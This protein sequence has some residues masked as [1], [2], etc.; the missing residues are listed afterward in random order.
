MFTNVRLQHFRSYDDQTVELNNGVNIV[1]G[2]NASGKTNLLEGLFFLCQGTGFRGKDANLIKNDGDWLRADGTT[3][4]GDRTFI[5]KRKEEKTAPEKELRFDGVV[6]KRITQTHT[7]PVTLFEPEHLRLLVG[8]PELRRGYL[9]AIIAQ[10]EHGLRQTL[11]EYRR[12]LSH[13]NRLL[14]TR[15][16]DM[17][18]QIFVWN[19]RLSELGADI[20]AQR[21]L[22]IDEINAQASETYSAISDKDSSLVFTYAPSISSSDYRSGF[23]KHLTDH[24]AIDIERGFTGKGPHREDFFVELNN[25]DA[26]TTASR[27][28]SR[29]IVLTA[30][31]IEMQRIFERTGTRPLLLFDD[32]FSELDGARRRALTEHLKE[33]Q[34]VITTTDADAIVKHFLSDY[35]VIATGD[36]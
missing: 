24:V 28:E 16:S 10:T 30:K 36:N 4:G 20:V 14:K 8:S 34:T 32:V 11:N 22:L 31:I 17:H 35:T 5:L 15:P 1:V 33:H 2:P 21:R 9:D 18:D 27:G 26:H 12:T 13:R 7:L 6:R 3:S 23:L 25:K 29:T 19:V